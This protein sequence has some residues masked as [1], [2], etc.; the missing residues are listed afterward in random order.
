MEKNHIYTKMKIKKT[1]YLNLYLYGNKITTTIKIFLFY[2]L[3]QY[4]SAVT[5]VIVHFV[6]NFIRIQITYFNIYTLL[7]P[8]K[9]FQ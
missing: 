1:D 6:L 4:P 7:L 3:T 9:N 2:Y 8:R 5:K